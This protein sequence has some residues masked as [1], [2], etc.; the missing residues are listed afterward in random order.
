VVVRVLSKPK[1]IDGQSSI[2]ADTKEYRNGSVD[3]HFVDWYWQDATG[4]VWNMGHSSA[5]KGESWQAG[6]RGATK[7][8]LLRAN[9][10]QGD[11]Y[12]MESAPGTAEDTAKV[13]SVSHKKVRLDVTSPL[14]GE[15]I[16]L[17]YKS[18][19]GLVKTIDKGEVT[20][21]T[22]VHHP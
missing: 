20:T 4:T 18:G 17:Y 16:R 22:S 10:T 8:V 15:T 9:P 19:V 2:G 6:K 3:E 13:A 1:T 11:S 14:F 5:R 12:K 21:L 7:G